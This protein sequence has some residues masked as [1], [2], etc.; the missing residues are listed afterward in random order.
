MKIIK[1]NILFILAIL[2][3]VILNSALFT[4]KQTETAIVL[5]FGEPI[6]VEKE[7]GLN[8]KIPML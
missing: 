3:Y 1:I 7:P 4:V 2:G 5:R 8:F 6:R